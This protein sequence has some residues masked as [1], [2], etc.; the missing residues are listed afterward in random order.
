MLLEAGDLDDAGIMP[1]KKTVHLIEKKFGDIAWL[2]KLLFVVYPDHEIFAKSYSYHRP[3]RADTIQ[4]LAVISNE[5]GF[6]DNVPMLTTAEQ[7]RT[8]Q[9]RLTKKQRNAL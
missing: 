2:V 6:F 7:A 9:L 4:N 8:R 1:Y 5:D 3:R